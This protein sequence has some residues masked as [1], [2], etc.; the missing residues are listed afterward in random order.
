MYSKVANCQK[1]LF[2]PEIIGNFKGGRGS[3]APPLVKNKLWKSMM[4]C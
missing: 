4:K 1:I 2:V 3:M